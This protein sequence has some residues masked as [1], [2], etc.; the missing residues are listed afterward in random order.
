[1]DAR[2]QPPPGE[3]MHRCLELLTVAA[4]TSVLLAGVPDC[5]A[6][7]VAST[8]ECEILVDTPLESEVIDAT[9]AGSYLLSKW[10]EGKAG[11]DQ[12]MFWKNGSREEV[13][14]R[15]DGYSYSYPSEL[16]ADDLV[17]CTAFR[18]GAYR[19]FRLESA[20]GDSYFLAVAKWL[21]SVASVFHL[22]RW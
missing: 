1:M 20:Y 15:L 5:R 2:S 7:G 13:V 9:D 14:P 11:H 10:R 8:T 22:Q 18:R 3:T 12:V 21:P 19:A 4:A 6:E 16:S 17:A